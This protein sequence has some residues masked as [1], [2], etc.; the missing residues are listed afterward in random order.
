MQRK[1][2]L[3]VSEATYMNSGYANYGSQIMQMLYDSKDFEI[4]E[5]SCH[6]KKDREYELSWKSYTNPENKNIF[7]KDVF[8]DVL[9]DFKPDIVWSF[10]D[11][12]VDDFIGNSVLK[13]HF[14]WVYMPTLDSLPLNIDWI[15][16]INKADYIFTYT[17]WGYLELKK[18]CPNISIEGSAPPCFDKCLSMVEDRSKFKESNGIN[19]DSYIIGS[20]MRNQKRKLIPD[21]M[22]AFQEFLEKSPQNI[23][24]NSFLYLHT[25]YPDVGWDIPRLLA[26]RPSISGKI[27]FSYNCNK[28]FK[29][30]ISPFCG[31]IIK[32]NHCNNISCTFPRVNKGTKKTD[33]FMVYNLMDL[34]VQYSCAEGFGMPLVEAASC[35]VPVC[36]VDYSAMTDVVRKLNGFPIKVQRYTY[37]VE[38]NRKFALPDNSNFVD[39]CIDFF[40]KPYA[41]RKS[42]SL[43]ARDSAKNNYNY[44]TTFKKIK[45]LFDSIEKSKTWNSDTIYISLNNNLDINLSEN[46]FIEKLFDSIPINFGNLKQKYLNKLYYRFD[47]KE[48]IL[49]E[50]NNIVN[51][52]NYY[53]NLRTKK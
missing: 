15:D 7:G 25:T 53:E 45:N 30:S 24:K 28:C 43:M 3:L 41:V 23:S 37:E 20:V 21:L 11:P 35:G 10:R 19:K 46:E 26:E 4:A 34:Y 33:M 27:L 40:K 51:N 5:L 16:T 29:L 32:C 47:T 2:V 48:N 52:F 8:E 31:S 49:N 9:I 39:V 36:A 12:W 22:D 18:L 6:G 38:T 42:I 50:I 14:K 17:D 44:Q 1:K 13:R